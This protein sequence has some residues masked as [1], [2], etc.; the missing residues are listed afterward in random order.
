MVN[1]YVQRKLLI[2]ELVK[3]IK[4]LDYEEIR[5]FVVKV[6]GEADTP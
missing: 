3:H 2:E 1:E 5:K 4:C 6:Q